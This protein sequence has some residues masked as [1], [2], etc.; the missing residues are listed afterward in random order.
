MILKTGQRERPTPSNCTLLGCLVAWAPHDWALSVTFATPHTLTVVVHPRTW[1]CSPSSSHYYSPS[2]VHYVS[3][4]SRKNTKTKTVYNDEND[5]EKEKRWKVWIRP[6]TTDQTYRKNT[7]MVS[8][9][10]L[11][12]W[13]VGWLLGWLVGRLIGF[14]VSRLLGCLRC[15]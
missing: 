3:S 7:H 8:G 2:S 4:S 11:V 12:Y 9:G 6:E 1:P 5:E 15:C 13:L 10:W 14:W